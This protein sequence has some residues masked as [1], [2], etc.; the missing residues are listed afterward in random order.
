VRGKLAAYDEFRDPEAFDRL[1]ARA[2]RSRWV[3]Y[4]KKPFRRAE[5]VIRYLGRYTHR[6]AISN[7]RFVSVTDDEV[8]FHTKDGKR[9]TLP[10][11]DFIRRFVQHV[12]PEGFHKIRHFGLYAGAA[13]AEALPAARAALTPCSTPPTPATRTTTT[14][15]DRLRELTGTDI[16]RCRVCG[17]LVDPLPLPRPPLHVRA[18]ARA[19]PVRSAA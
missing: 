10:P 19:P 11:V 3:V 4:A 8:T 1:M 15:R 6:V 9:A 5:H 14:W 2:S 13:V 16:D 18:A 17:G 12:L 7:S